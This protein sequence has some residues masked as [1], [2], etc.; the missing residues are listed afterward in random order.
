MPGTGLP[1]VT[2]PGLAPM[3][4]EP[5]PRRDPRPPV[6]KGVIVTGVEPA[7]TTVPDGT[8]AQPLA[9]KKVLPGLMTTGE[10]AA[11]S[12]PPPT[13]VVT[14]AEPLTTS[15]CVLVPMVRV[16]PAGTVAVVPGGMGG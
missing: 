3:V 11:T 2:P 13:G 15:V 14:V 4:M 6:P 10:N 1:R 7:V 12:M 8:P 5:L 9:A 16:L